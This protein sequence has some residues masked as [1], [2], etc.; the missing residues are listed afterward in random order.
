MPALTLL[1]MRLC[2]LVP[3]RE[4]YGS[5]SAAQKISGS[6]SGAD[7]VQINRSPFKHACPSLPTIKWSCT[8]IPSGFATSTIVL[9]HLDAGMRGCRIAG[10]MIVHQTTETAYRT[11]NAHLFDKRRG[12]EGRGLGAVRVSHFS[13]SR[14]ITLRHYS[15]K[16]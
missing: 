11:E 7:V 9:R 12:D 15:C 8:E 5:K 14:S 1:L 10:G 2:Y 16:H 4:C 6:S 3:A 13:M